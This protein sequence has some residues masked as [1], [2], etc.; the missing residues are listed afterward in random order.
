[1]TFRKCLF[2]LAGALVLSSA[3]PQGAAAASVD[4]NFQAAINRLVANIDR[5][6]VSKWDKGKKAELAA[7]IGRKMSGISQKKKQH[8]AAAKS[9]GEL[10]AR[11]D[12]VS[13]ENRYELEREIRRDCVEL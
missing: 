7:C 4:A 13:A 1:M 10:R 2:G 11:F 12:E 5:E 3:A 8:I 9:A 6:P